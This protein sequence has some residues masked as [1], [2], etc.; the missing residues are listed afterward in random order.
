M[1][2]RLYTVDSLVL[3]VRSLLDENNNDALQDEDI[4]GSLNRA[5]D[6][7][8]DIISYQ[9]PEPYITYV[10]VAV[11]ASQEYYP[12]PED[13]YSDRVTKIEFS[14]STPYWQE[15]QRISY[16][17]ITPYDNGN[18]NT[19]SP[20]Y[21]TIIGND[22]KLVP[23]ATGTMRVWYVRSPEE[24][25]PALGRVLKVN[26]VDQKLIIDNLSTELTTTVSDLSSYFNV[27]DGQTGR[28]KGT[29]QA[30]T[31]TSNSVVIKQVGV[32]P[33]VIN[34]T[35]LTTIE[36]AVDSAGNPS[37]QE[38]DYICA[39]NGT[40]VPYF[41]RPASNFVIE[42]AVAELKRKLGEGAAEM[43]ERLKSALEKH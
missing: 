17:D 31:L 20:Q 26:L 38:N 12:I 33:S 29:F 8:V 15:V 4:L 42:Y 43:E 28:V 1:S 19:L 39:L 25:V 16:R 24:L 40:C 6:H 41:S 32:T 9:Y 34:R 37:V 21:Y 2:R 13:C 36:S 27:V 11:T 10:D 7:A 35:I 30:R 14:T 22:L 3:A 5:Q 18:F 23:R